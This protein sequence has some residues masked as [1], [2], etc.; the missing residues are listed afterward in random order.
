MTAY[1]VK[2][3]FS[4]EDL[5]RLHLVEDEVPYIVEK[6]VLLR[7]IDYENFI[8]DLC[9]SRWFIE[10]NSSLC[11]VDQEGRWHCL[12]VMQRQTSNGVLVMSAGEDYPQYAAVAQMKS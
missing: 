6:T 7:K 2:L 9:V 3:P 10:E 8:N 1:F 5:Y 11:Q 12:L 4:I